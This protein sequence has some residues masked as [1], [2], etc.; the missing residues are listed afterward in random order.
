MPLARGDRFVLRDA[1]AGLTFGGGVVVDPLPPPAKGKETAALID[2][3]WRAR[4]T[5][6]LD[7]LLSAEG[8]LS[9]QDVRLRIGLTQIPEG[10]PNLGGRLFSGP[11]AA[12][13]IEGARSHL[14]DHHRDF[15][16]ERGMAKAKLS[17]LLELDAEVADDLLARDPGTV[18]EGSLV[19]L[20]SHAVSIT[21]VQIEER[22][23]VVARLD[24]AR[25]SPPVS[26]DLEVEPSLLRALEDSGVLVRIADFHLTAG[27]MDELK[28]VVTSAIRERGPQTVAEIR[29]L[30]GTT[31]RFALPLCEWMDGARITR[32]NG[33]LRS[34]GPLA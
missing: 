9:L 26:A 19:R 31:R 28:A 20:A 12:R 22:D 34:L 23:A 33:N 27:R 10:I 25:F 1:G 6:A 18:V 15:P 4:G 30:L 13:L 8:E 14:R 32:R 24:A 16:L 11:R 17:K 2:A 21:P 29:D 7:V 3:L 5:D